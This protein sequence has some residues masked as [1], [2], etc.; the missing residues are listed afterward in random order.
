MIFREDNLDVVY[1][2]TR[3]LVNKKYEVTIKKI[4]G[5][6]YYYEKDNGETGIMD[7]RNSS[8][9]NAKIL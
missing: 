4:V 9:K 7:G 6:S 2:G 3:L 5:N 8:F 1:V